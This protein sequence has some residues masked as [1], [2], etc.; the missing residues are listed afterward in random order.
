MNTKIIEEIIVFVLSA[1]ALWYGIFWLYRDHTVEQFRQRLFELRSR[2]FD[3]A[4]N[5]VIPFNHP[6]YVLLRSAINGF[7][8]FGHRISLFELFIGDKL[9]ASKNKV[10]FNYTFTKSLESLDLVTADKLNKYRVRMI[11][12]V[13]IQAIA[14]SPVFLVVVIS[15]LIPISFF[16]VIKYKILKLCS[17]FFSKPIDALES[18]ALAYGR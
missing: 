1:T 8:R 12:L 3:E 2:L 6:S 4:A 11:E 9:V 5:G 17:N 13:V 18:E 16:I 7:L 10:S 15:Y 14:A